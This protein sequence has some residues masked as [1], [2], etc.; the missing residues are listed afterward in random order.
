MPVAQSTCGAHNMTLA[1]LLFH[2]F[3]FN[4]L[5]QIKVQQPL[6]LPDQ[7]NEFER[8]HLQTPAET[9]CC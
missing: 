9:L 3:Q 7:E 5:D 2:L 1:V 4:Q 6:I 8:L